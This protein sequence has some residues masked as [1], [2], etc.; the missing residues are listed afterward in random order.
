MF[1]FFSNPSIKFILAVLALLLGLP[2]AGAQAPPNPDLNH[3]GVVNTL[4]VSIVGKCLNKNL[5]QFPECR[6]ADT[7][8]D[9]VVDITDYRI[10]TSAYGRKGYPIGPNPCVTGESPPYSR[11]RTGSDGGGDAAGVS[12]RQR[13]HGCGPRL[14]HL[15]LVVCLPPGG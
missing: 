10:V 15:R 3:D 4:D 2:L 8:G 12:G 6:C 7:N 11:C 13:L 5:T 9:N 14:A 1:K